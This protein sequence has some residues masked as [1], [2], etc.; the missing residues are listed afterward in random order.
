MRQGPLFP[1]DALAA[2]V[3]GVILLVFHKNIVTKVIEINTNVFHQKIGP[4]AKIWLRI[5]AL[6]GSCAIIIFA[7][8]LLINGWW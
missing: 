6:I 5:Q 4:K 1:I 3:F 2:L 7:I 8:Y